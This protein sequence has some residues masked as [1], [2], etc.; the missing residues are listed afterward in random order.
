MYCKP[1]MS[2]TL[3]DKLK[4]RRSR[5]NALKRLRNLD[6]GD[7]NISSLTFDQES[8]SDREKEDTGDTEFKK[9]EELFLEWRNHQG[10]T[11]E[12]ISSIIQE[13][14]YEEA[15]AMA[16]EGKDLSEAS[17]AHDVAV[18]HKANKYDNFEK[19]MAYYLYQEK[20]ETIAK[21]NKIIERNDS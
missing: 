14:I 16:N 11:V 19:E 7:T 12:D 1:L 2:S 9:N 3:E 15:H 18:T 20:K 21:L 4:E 13:Q 5:V 17:D 10:R 8:Q 6:A